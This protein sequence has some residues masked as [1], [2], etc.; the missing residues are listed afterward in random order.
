MRSARSASSAYAARPI[1]R[2]A[3]A[4]VLFGSGT[5][6][7]RLGQASADDAER[8][9]A[10]EQRRLENEERPHAAQERAAA[11]TTRARG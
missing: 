2:S 6:G 10:G 8:E 4:A 1:A 11:G 3:S 5:G 7:T 9:H